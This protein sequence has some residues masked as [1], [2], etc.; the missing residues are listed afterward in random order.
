VDLI[1]ATRTTW[2]VLSMLVASSHLG[3]TAQNW[4]TR[5]IEMIIPYAAGGGV[6][7]VGRAV[8]GSLSEQ[9]GQSVAVVNRDGA[10]GTLGFN[11]LASATPDGYT[12]G[13]G[14]TTPIT[15][16]P[17]LIKGVR[18]QADSFDYICQV[19]ENVFAI[20]VEPG[21]RFNSAKD[22]FA[23]ATANPG[24]LNYGHAGHGSIPHLS[25]ENLA[26]ALKLKFQPAPFR[27]DPPMLA[28]MLKGDLDFG[29]PS[30]ASIRGQNFRVLAVFDD[31]RHPTLPDVPTAKEL[32]VATSV[33]PGYNG[34]YAPKGLP[35]QVRKALQDACS[36]AVQNDTVARAIGN[37]GQ[38]VRYLTGGQFEARTA[39]DF[40]FK[41][42]LIRRLG[43][44]GQ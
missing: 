29:V 34:I 15:S 17:Y 30:L 27:G 12:L 10:G 6:D 39:A 8:A 5:P 37:T 42:E 4:P 3:A 25:V 18:Y 19:F 11:V 26:E 20:A 23:A 24:R 41:G 22:L 32:G 28:V 33:P 1:P 38:V 36:K 7:I 31:E 43:L 13:A 16:S 14:P 9:F 44:A 35:S 21:S 40:T 2:L